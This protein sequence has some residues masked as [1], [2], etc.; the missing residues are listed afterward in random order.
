MEKSFLLLKFLKCSKFLKNVAL[1][2]LYLYFILQVFEKLRVSKTPT[3]VR[4]EVPRVIT[5]GK[6]VLV[7]HHYRKDK[8]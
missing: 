5:N 3:P 4:R 7:D 6:K 2:H 8:V 1:V